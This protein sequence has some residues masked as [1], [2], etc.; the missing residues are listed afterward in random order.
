MHI[1]LTRPL[2]DIQE[3]IAVLEKN[4]EL[5]RVKTE[6]DKNRLQEKIYQDKQIK[7][8]KLTSIGTLAAGITHEINTPLT[9][10]KGNFE[11]MQYD[12]ESLPEDRTKKNMLEDGA[13]INEAISRIENIVESM[14]E[15]SQSSSEK[16]EKINIYSTLI[17]SLTMAYNMSKQISR[18]YLNGKLFGINSIDKNA[19]TFFANVQK[20]RVGQ[21]WIIIINNALD[22]LKKMDDYEKRVLNIS[23]KIEDKDLLIQF[24]DNAD[25]SSFLVEIKQYTIFILGNHF[26]RFL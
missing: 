6:V 24:I 20:Q 14:R 7:S 9:Y 3:L 25:P 16:K 12:I 2:E 10:L 21:V 5:K 22:E 4:G 17:T 15:V 26:H 18:I 13:K 8:A 19:E 23:I 1:L 11:M